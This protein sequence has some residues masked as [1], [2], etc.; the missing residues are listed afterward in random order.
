MANCSFIY[1]GFINYNIN[2]LKM[3]WGKMYSVPLNCY[4]SSLNV[5]FK[6]Q[7]RPA[8]LKYSS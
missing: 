4:I 3:Q 6:V 8:V 2:L 7:V 1:P 5:T